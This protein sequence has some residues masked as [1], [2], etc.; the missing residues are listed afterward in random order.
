MQI[1]HNPS[2]DFLGKTKVLLVVS[3]TLI[4]AGMAFIATQGVRYGVEFSGG[5]QLIARFQG[6]PEVEKVR[7]AVDKV[8]TG[9]TIQTYDDPSKNQVL[10]CPTP[11]P[12]TRTSLPP[13]RP[14][15]RP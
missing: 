3:T 9:A 14:C 13:P 1:L 11:G 2:Y 6:R 7:S 10:I 8:V 15:S 5:T 4:L 12:R